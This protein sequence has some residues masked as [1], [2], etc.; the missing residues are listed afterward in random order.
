MRGGAP[1]IDAM[2]AALI[3][4]RE[5]HITL[6]AD[7]A[8][9]AQVDIMNEM[10][11]A[12]ADVRNLVAARSEPS[13]DDPREEIQDEL[14]GALEPAAAALSFRLPL[15]LNY[16]PGRPAFTMQDQVLARQS[17]ARVKDQAVKFQAN[18]A[19]YQNLR[20][21]LNDYGAMLEKTRTALKL[22]VAALDNPPNLEAASEDLYQI[23]FSVKRDIEAFRAARQ[24]AQ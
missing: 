16:T 21:A 5:D 12:A 14:N 17:I 22:L 2:L 24:A 4:E 8:N 15:E 7:E 3:E 13:G 11:P 20:N 6:R 9:L 19:A 1:V 18:M 23:A 10:V